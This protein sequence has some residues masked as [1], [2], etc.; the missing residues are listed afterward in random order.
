M[1]L[2]HWK[3]AGSVQIRMVRSLTGGLDRRSAGG[4]TKFLS[5]G[6]LRV[7]MFRWALKERMHDY[8]YYVYRVVMKC[9]YVLEL[10]SEHP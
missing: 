5:E 1:D 6:M 10:R 9:K 2:W 4:F 7:G 3:I 8:K